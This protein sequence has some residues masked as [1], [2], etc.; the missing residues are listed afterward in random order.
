MAAVTGTSRGAEAGCLYGLNTQHDPWRASSLAWRTGGDDDG[1]LGAA[2]AQCGFSPSRPRIRVE[3]SI[4]ERGQPHVLGDPRNVG[5][6][7]EKAWKLA[8]DQLGAVDPFRTIGALLID[9]LDRR[10]VRCNPSR[11]IGEFRSKRRID[12]SQLG[13]EFVPLSQRCV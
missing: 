8:R 13:S 7:V 3:P 2:A 5:C 4:L 12:L 9:A 1:L 6:A 11:K 10:I